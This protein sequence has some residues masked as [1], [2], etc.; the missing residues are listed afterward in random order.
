VPNETL[1]TVVTDRTIS[2]ILEG[3]E[4]SSTKVPDIYGGAGSAVSKTY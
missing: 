4:T 1:L 3:K 2:R